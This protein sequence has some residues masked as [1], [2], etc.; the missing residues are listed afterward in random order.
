MLLLLHIQLFL[1]QFLS[2]IPCAST[3]MKCPFKVI[4][5]EKEW[6]HYYKP[7]DYWI[8][9]IMSR[10]ISRLYSFSFSEPPTHQLKSDNTFHNIFPFLLAVHE[11]NQNS[12]LSPNISL[13]YNIYENFFSAR[14]TYEAMLDV[15]STGQENIPNYR[16]GKQKNLLAILEEMDS[17]L[18]DHIS[19]VLSIYKIPQINYSVINQMAE[20]NH[21]FPFSYRMT[22]NQEPPDSAIIQLLLQFQWTWIG[23]LSQDNEKGEKFKRSLEVLALK[24]GICIVLS[25][26]VPEANVQTSAGK[27]LTVRG[28]CKLETINHPRLYSHGRWC[29]IQDV[30]KLAPQ[31]MP[32][33]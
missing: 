2:Q 32:S 3:L 21:R 11:V 20:Q 18:F 22:P 4:I 16:C 8:T 19:N 10:L 6:F 33:L 24:N 15:L 12:R 14:M 25:G 23:L 5:E 17:E 30:Q 27:T 7:G 9:G 28:E 13:G 31:V 29:L 1:L 26:T